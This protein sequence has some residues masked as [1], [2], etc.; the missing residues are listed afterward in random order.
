VTAPVKALLFD[1][2]GTLVDSSAVLRRIMEQWC[3]K[4]SLPLQSTLDVCH[5]RR[6]EE[7]IQIVA[8][9][10]CAKSEAAEIDNLEGVTLEGLVPIEGAGRLLK[11]LEPGRWAVVTSSAMVSAKPKLSACGLPLPQVLITADSVANGKPHP[12]PYRRAAEAL[13]VAPEHCLVFEDSDT[14]VSSALAAGCRAMLVGNSCL[15]H[16]PSIIGRIGT[17]AKFRLTETGELRT[18]DTFVARLIR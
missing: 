17:F 5:G 6:T 16:H 4:H 1:L 3:I 12:E 9:H 14:G 10:L 8:P 13:G 15:M 2:D 7:T 11:T 18:D